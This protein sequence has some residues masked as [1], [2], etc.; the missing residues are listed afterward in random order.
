[1]QH[2]IDK[3]DRHL[4]WQDE[5]GDELLLLQFGEVYKYS[6]S[7]LR[8]HCFSFPAA[9][10]IRKTIGILAESETEDPFY[11]LDVE[12]A[13]LGQLI[14][15]GRFKRRPHINGRWIKDKERILAHRIIPYEPT[16]LHP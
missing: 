2:L 11:I 15:L 16:R 8:V 12:T 1:M 6:D 5:C 7:V 10:Q 4:L 13:K 9:A 14:A 3:E